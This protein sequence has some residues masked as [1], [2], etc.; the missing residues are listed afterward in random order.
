MQLKLNAHLNAYSRAPFYQDWVRDIAPDGEYDPNIVWARAKNESG[1]ITWVP[2][3]KGLLDDANVKSLLS[4]IETAE[5]TVDQGLSSIYITAPKY[6][7][8]AKQLVVKF[9]NDH[10]WELNGTKHYVQSIAFPVAYPDN[11]TIYKDINNSLFLSTVNNPDNDTIEIVPDVEKETSD[12]T[13]NI[14]SI[15]TG[16]FRARGLHVETPRS[17]WTENN[18]LTGDAIDTALRLYDT[19][20]SD[21]RAIVQGDSGYLAPMPS[22]FVKEGERV[23]DALTRWALKELNLQT[24]VQ[25]P[26]NTKVLFPE[27]SPA[28]NRNL[29]VFVTEHIF[30]DPWI[31]NGK[32]VVVEATN[33]GVLGVVTGSNKKY[34]VSIVDGYE[35]NHIMHRGEMKVNGLEEEFAKVVYQGTNTSSLKLNQAYIQTEED[36]LVRQD[37]ATAPIENTLVERTAL[38]T[39]QCNEPTTDHEAVNVAWFKQQTITDDEISDILMEVF[40]D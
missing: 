15:T 37:I 23:S 21:I 28:S 16:K 8:E 24:V 1:D 22:T 30:T 35:E 17:T 26:N 38:G 14:E 29:Y 18:R 4:R 10:G 11:R 36:Q 13:G 2:I 19:E 3:N 31:D 40:N 12:A 5:T 20:L 32:D 6:D 7:P 33:T 25:I 34:H 27:D 39:I 9:Y